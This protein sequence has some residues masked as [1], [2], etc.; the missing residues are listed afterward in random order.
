MTGTDGT[1][2]P[3]VLARA[4]RAAPTSARSRPPGRWARSCPVRPRPSQIA[5]F[6]VALRAKGETV[7]EVEGLV[8]AMYAHATPLDDRGPGPRRRRH[9]WRPV[10]LGEHLHD[11]GDR[12][13]GRRCPGGQARQPVGVVEGGQ[14]RRAREARASGSTCRRPTSPGSSSEA[15]ITFCFAAAFHP[16][17][18]HAAVRPPRARRRP[19][20]STSSARSPTRP[21]RPPRRSAAPT[22]RMA[23]VMAGVFARR[24][25][26]AWVF[27]GDDGLDELTTT[28]T[29]SA[30][31]PCTTARSPSTRSTR[32]RS[33]CPWAPPRACAVGDADHNADVVRRLLAGEPGPVRDAVVLNAG[34][35]LAVHAARGGLD[36]RAA[37]RP[38]IAPGQRRP[39]LRCRAGDAR[40]LGRGDVGLAG[41]Q[42]ESPAV[43]GGGEADPLVVRPDHRRGGDDAREAVVAEHA[44]AAPD[45]RAGREV[46][47]AR[48]DPVE[49]D[50]RRAVPAVVEQ[51][52]SR[53]RREGRSRPQPRM[54]SQWSESQFTSGG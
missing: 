38:G 43:A 45:E 30:C 14:R 19:P 1:T 35:A 29:S 25:V 31:G 28:T 33:A 18:R 34:A 3:E 2:W 21:G 13:R 32:R 44:A 37:G 42:V 20:P 24:G 51:P 6:A 41:P 16:A 40:P 49:V 10:V 47:E 23:P 17:L 54:S 36:R 26:D 39:R 4:R 53:S 12:R 15:G 22:G 52:A 9:R 27:R 46:A 7:E 8:A 5:G 11:G 48:A 50:V